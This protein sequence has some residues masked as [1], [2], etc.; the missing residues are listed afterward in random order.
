MICHN[1]VFKYARNKNIAI[2]F[3][4]TKKGSKGFLCLHQIKGGTFVG[5]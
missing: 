4:K 3:G 5:S 1:K 2:L